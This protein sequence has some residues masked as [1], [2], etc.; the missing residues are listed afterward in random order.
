MFMSSAYFKSHAIK[1]PF[2]LFLHKALQAFHDCLVVSPHYSL[3]MH[4]FLV[5]IVNGILQKKLS[6]SCQYL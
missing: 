1:S 5:T 3:K 4:A 6:F 2:P